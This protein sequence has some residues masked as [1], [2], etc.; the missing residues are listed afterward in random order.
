MSQDD[1]SSFRP[2]AK[3]RLFVTLAMVRAD[4]G[5][6]AD[7]APRRDGIQ[8]WLLE[9]DLTGGRLWPTTNSRLPRPRR[10]RGCAVNLPHF[11][12][13]EAIET[14]EQH[15]EPSIS[16]DLRARTRSDAIAAVDCPNILCQMAPHPANFAYYRDG[17]VLEAA[18]RH[19]GC[20]WLV[21]MDIKDF[22]ESI[23][24][25]Q[26]CRVFRSLGYGA[27]LS[28]ELAR[29]CTRFD[30]TAYVRKPRDRSAAYRYRREGRL[31]QGAPTSPAL[32][33]LVVRNLD[34][35]LEAAAATL[36]WA[37]TRYADDLAFSIRAAS[38]RDEARKVIAFVK[39]ALPTFGLD[40]NNA[41]RVIAPPGARRI[42]LGLLVDC[43]QPRLTR[44]FRDNLETHLH[45]L[46]A[47]GIGLEKHRAFRG[48][49]S[50]I[51]MRRHIFGLLAFAHYIE[52]VFAKRC[53]DR[54]NSIVWSDWLQL[55]KNRASHHCWYV[56]IA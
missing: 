16:D 1:L 35:H 55:S 9:P 30:D 38:T 28:F 5:G 25:S 6:R 42:V 17:G 45:A 41:K 46:T 3:P 39:A 13:K 44:N 4:R 53:Y 54:F 56:R 11:P 43:P 21:K 20:T 23:T 26:V 10:W 31:P 51:G 27:L 22:F 36:G 33:N 2:R 48:F 34:V 49:A 18:R 7:D 40:P 8:M 52:P 37:Y 12:V 50:T 32:A 47:R 29:I 19:A 15:A 14:H 24:E